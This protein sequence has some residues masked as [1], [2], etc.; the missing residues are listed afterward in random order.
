MSFLIDF[1][2]ATTAATASAIRICPKKLG[3]AAGRLDDI[4]LL[5]QLLNKIKNEG[6]PS[7]SLY[8]SNG[9]A[10]WENCQYYIGKN[11]IIVC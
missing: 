11:K 6:N 3:P 7:L 10:L 4:T 8:E 1:L 5:K 9:T 2:K